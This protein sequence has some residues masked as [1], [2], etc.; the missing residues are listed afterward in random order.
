M[1]EF[2]QS[3]STAVRRRWIMTLVSSTDG[4]TGLTAQTGQ[5][6]VSKNGG[7]PAL[8]TNSIVEVDATNMPGLYYI[9]LT[10]AELNTLGHIAIT[11]KNAASLAFQ[12]RA[13]VSYNDP[14][15]SVGGFSGGTTDTFK[16][17][18]KHIEAI[19]EEVWKYKMTEDITAKDKLMQ[20]SEHPIVDLSGLSAE[21]K[22]IVMPELDLSPVLQKVEAIKYPDLDLTPVL[23][24]IDQIKIP[25]C[26]A[27]DLDGLAAKITA[28]IQKL[29]KPDMATPE[30][31]KVVAE[32]SELKTILDVRLTEMSKEDPD[33]NELLYGIQ[34]EMEDKF[35]E[36]M[37]K[38]GDDHG[39]LAKE[40]I[41]T[42]FE[43]LEDLH[44]G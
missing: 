12:D 15:T 36:V 16:L 3:E 24:K 28:E 35:E 21:I 9:E 22:G 25:E 30:V 42:K 1:L 29:D 43:I 27:P 41:N 31:A 37:N 19:A 4:V 20:A 26:P 8:S 32:L 14:F 5:V 11:K 7:T 17:T 34:N 33:G 44:N 13:L 10:A 6:Y 38:L 40:I 18:K 2:K 39:K 23:D